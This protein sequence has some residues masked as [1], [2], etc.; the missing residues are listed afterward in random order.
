[1]K[2][3]TVAA[4][5]VLLAATTAQAG[6]KPLYQPAPAW[7]L[8]APAIDP[9]KDD[10][11]PRVILDQQQRLANGEVWSYVDTASR[12][13]SQQSLLEAGTII[14]GWQPDEG[15]LIVHRIAILRGSETIDLL[16]EKDALTVLRRERGL[17][18]LELDGVLTATMPVKGLQVGDIVRVTY[19]I[20]RS[21]PA[22]KGAMQ[23]TATLL[24]D[25]TQVGFARIRALWPAGQDVKW[26]ALAKV[27]DA[28]VRRVGAFDELTVATPMPKQP[29]LPNDAPA[30]FHPLPLVELS[31][32][33]DWADVS[34]T[35]APL[36][37]AQAFAAGSPLAA[38]A[39]RIRAAASD[40]L[41]RAA[42]ALES[43][44]GNVR[45]LFNGLDHGNYVPQPPEKTW[46]IRSGD[47]KAKTLLLLSLLKALDVPAEPVL[48][49]VH[50]GDFLPGRLPSA[51]AFNHILVAA[52]VGG[53]TYWLDGTGLGTRP[54]D[55]GDTPN[56]RYVLPL[57]AAGAGLLPLATHANARPDFIIE[58]GRDQSAGLGLPVPTSLVVTLRGPL[59]EALKAA[60][61]QLSG[62]KRKAMIDKLVNSAKLPMVVVTRRIDYDDAAGAATVRVTALTNG[63]WARDD[64]HYQDVLDSVVGDLKFDGD[65][66]RPE[67]RALPVATAGPQ[68]RVTRARVRLPDGGKG[69]VLEGDQTLP[70]VLAGFAV[71]RQAT[72]ADGVV[73]VEDRLDTTAAEIAPGDI[74][75]TRAA[76]ALAKSRAFKVSAPRDYPPHWRVVR[77]AQAAGKL[78]P[79]E[80]AFASAIADATEKPPLL[81]ARAEFRAGVF[82]RTG[83]I[84]D[85]TT[86]IAA[87]PTVQVL[88]TRAWLLH[89]T[90]KDSAALADDK[91]AYDLDPGSPRALGAYAGMLAQTGQ[92][93]AALA[94]LDEAIAAGGE[95]KS[96]M[97]SAKADLLA[98]DH[99]T[100]AALGAID[101]AIRLKPGDA[102][103][104]NSRCWLKG[105]LG[106]QLDTALKDCTKALELGVDSGQALDSRAMV[107]LKLNRLDDARTDIDAA[108]IERPDQAGS[109]FLRGVIEARQGAK[110]AST[111]DL[112]GARMEAP[113]IDEEY[114]RFGVQVG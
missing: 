60:D 84:A 112:T 12:V 11:A 49:N 50:L 39:A 23:S 59:V 40:P 81:V 24:P 66:G 22:L 19:S 76:L 108:L 35:M 65:R 95:R 37:A 61:K 15:D 71:A 72:L 16:A 69:F 101:A 104:L 53:K 32:F 44:Q 42:L 55:L 93:A 68:S 43:V 105:T 103:L 41:A 28:K 107:F 90:G 18:S 1:M 86:V 45:Y 31:T 14:L 111:D 89:A 2:F 62:D 98:R 67:W 73:V 3:T 78:K 100:D 64:Q 75:A 99:Q 51:A 4:F 27:G 17:E 9:A 63:A 21:D 79:I 58:I 110:P 83:A 47:C 36:F 70:P 113:R 102:G 80:A 8:P 74:A 82:D 38:E 10:S 5:G 109:L 94:L 91:A 87:R 33:R 77:A 20:T 114:R 34:R 92:Q 85:L 96:A 52:T 88:L 97:L 48:A 7:V 46:A 56:L 13:T 29:D 26:K 54:A 6:T 25:Q 106:V 57:R 30:R